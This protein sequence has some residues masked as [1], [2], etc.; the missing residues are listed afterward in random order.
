MKNRKGQQALDSS[1]RVG[2]DKMRP[3]VIDEAAK[4]LAAYVVGYAL[5]PENHYRPSVPGTQPP[6]DNQNHC[7]QINTYRCG[8]SITQIDDRLYRHFSVSVPG[9]RFPNVAAVLMLAEI[10]GF[11]GW[12]QKTINKLPA[13]WIARIEPHSRAVVVAQLME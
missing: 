7:C 13:G 6:G 8:F 1:A 9:T 4:K 12:D 2:N 5:V 10:F 11:T 3:L